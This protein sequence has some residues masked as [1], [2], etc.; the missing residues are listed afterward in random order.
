MPNQTALA[1]SYSPKEIRGTSKMYLLETPLHCVFENEEGYFVIR[2]EMLDIIG[3][4]ETEEEAK[5]SFAVEF[6]Y[7]YTRYNELADEQL[8]ERLLKIKKIL[9]LIV[10]N[11]N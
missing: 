3:T 2:N 6:D 11:I 7:I 4:G 1:W 8:S 5:N 10:K 9:S